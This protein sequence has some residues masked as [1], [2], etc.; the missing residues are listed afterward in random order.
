MSCSAI[1]VNYNTGKMLRKVVDAALA[2]RD[3][4]KIVVVDNNSQDESMKGIR[5]S[6]RLIKKYREENHGFGSS[7]NYGAKFV[8]SK[9]L[10]FLNPDCIVEK[11]SIKVLKNNLEQDSNIAIIGCRVNNPDG[12]EQRASRRR[13]PTL[14][15][16]LK[17]FS[18]LENLAKYYSG[19]AGVN[20]NHSVIGKSI[21]K[22]EAI[23]GALIMIRSSAFKQIKGFDEKFPLHF[24]DLDLFKRTLDCGYDILINQAV[25]VVHYQGISSQ[26]NP[27]VAMYKKRGL[28]RYFSKHCSF[29]A[30]HIVKILNKIRK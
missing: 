15:R 26:S 25:T 21:Q 19:F 23:S 24:E 30:Y 6:K 22:V 28:E 7:C 29:L 27:R 20:L 3:I 13:L 8:E 17:T 11:D 12:T 10:L 2:N 5:T 9:Y 4:E 1:I 16:A 14:W 18:K